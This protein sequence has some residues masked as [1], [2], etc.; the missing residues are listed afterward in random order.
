[1]RWLKEFDQER[2]GGANTFL[3]FGNVGD[4]FPR[5]D[6]DVVAGSVGDDDL[7]DTLDPW[8]TAMVRH[9]VDQQLT[10]VFDAARGFTFPNPLDEMTFRGLWNPDE[11][12]PAKDA[13]AQARQAL[14]QQ[15][16]LPELPSNAIRAMMT[17]F[18]RARQTKK[19]GLGKHISCVAILP[20]LDVICPAGSAG[21]RSGSKVA[22]AI[23]QFAASDVF[24]RAGHVMLMSAATLHALDERLRRPDVPLR[25]IVV[26]KPDYDERCRHLH[27]VCRGTASELELTHRTTVAE[28]ALAQERRRA[29]LGVSVQAEERWFRLQNEGGLPFLVAQDGEVGAL[30]TA[31]ERSEAALTAFQEAAEEQRQIAIEELRAEKVELT[32]RAREH[33]QFSWAVLDDSVWDSMRVGDVIFIDTG[34]QRGERTVLKRLRHG[35]FHLSLPNAPLAPHIGASDRKLR[36]SWHEGS[37][38]ARESVWSEPT[39]F[40]HP[41]GVALYI[42][43]EA[44]AATVRLAAIER[45]LVRL[46]EPDR[47]SVEREAAHKHVASQL[48][49]AEARAQERIVKTRTDTADRIRNLHVQMRNPVGPEIDRLAARVAQIARLIAAS[50]PRGYFPFPD[51]GIPE[52]A[53]LI[54]GFGYRDIVATLRF[55]KGLGRTVGLEEFRRHRHAILTRAY[56]HYLEIVEPAYGFDGIAGLS[57]V[58]RFLLEVRNAIQA[59]DLRH[60]PMGCLLMGPPGTGKSAVAEAFARECGFLFVKLRNTRSMWVGESER[61]MEEVLQGLRDLAPVVVYRDE[62]DEEDTGRDSFQGDSG[63]S[64][65]IRRMWM[66]FLA[67]PT[68]RGRVFVI[69]CSNRPD[70]MDAALKRSGRTDERIPMLMPDASTRAELFPV[71]V[72]RYGYQC[73]IVDFTPFA[74]KTDGLSGADIEVI[75]RRAD[76]FAHERGLDAIDEEALGR[77]IGDFIPSASLIFIAIMTALAII[78]CSS[79]QYLP[80]AIWEIVEW[81]NRVLGFPKGS[82]PPFLLAERGSPEETGDVWRTA[83][84]ERLAGGVPAG[85]KNDSG[86]PN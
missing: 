33:R 27:H 32:R 35:E 65:R 28:L 16:P 68:I 64:A 9:A 23:L 17:V 22:L 54:Q 36:F 76:A 50:G 60:V 52:V 5:Y 8:E 61:T 18:E 73:G 49:G 86:K 41:R 75:V 26:G 13:L 45:E 12:Q 51:I 1:M 74:Q 84:Q 2:A 46:Q 62:V 57:G 82:G 39:L 19:K 3:F 34:D 81:I 66:Q 14:D 20:D 25:A 56:G 21:D 78:E 67:D 31:F 10:W 40:V 53:R 72:R 29:E 7:V 58:K 11:A 70:R 37:L 15:T 69:S 6:N 42:P 30:R 77:A 48:A 83:L 38:Y 63:V 85:K 80:E 71:M 55:A 79:R 44:K 43:K 47:E 4:G 59:G 24:R